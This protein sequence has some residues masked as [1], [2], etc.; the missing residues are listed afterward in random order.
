MQRETNDD[1]VSA[2]EAVVTYNG[3]FYVVYGWKDLEPDGVTIKCPADYGDPDPDPQSREQLEMLWMI[4]VLLFGD[5][6]VSPRFGWIE[7]VD[8]FRE[9]VRR[10]SEESVKY[11]EMT[12]DAT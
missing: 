4:A 5:Y 11:E 12:R 8:D 9:W 7:N 2:L 10:I 1:Y 6:G 3:L